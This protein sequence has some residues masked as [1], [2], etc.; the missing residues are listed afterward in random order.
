MKKAFC[1]LIVL[2]FAFQPLTGTMNGETEPV[3]TA[4]NTISVKA[5]KL[6]IADS[7]ISSKAAKSLT[8]YKICVDPG[9]GGTDPGAIGPTGYEEADANL[10]IGL[11]LRDLLVSDGATVYM[12][13]TDD[14]YLTN[15]DRY[16][17][18]N[19]TD[20][21]I[22]VSIH[23]NGSTD[24]GLNYTQGLYAKWK[25]DINLASTIHN[26][27]YPS[28]EIPDG[29][30]LQFASGVILK[31]EM[32]ATIQEVAFISNT[33]ECGLLTNG[34]GERQEQIAQLLYSGIN[35]WFAG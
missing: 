25:K 12:T 32:P 23:F 22:L 5:E 19:S 33:T 1:L 14:I 18:A 8:G 9:H 20:G 15:R 26:Q 27:L 3:N 34:T 4:G 11:R 13:R 6:N 10:D 28:L 17:Y 35:E 7:S 21:E 24:H 2:F 16:T 30:L 29:G 31:A